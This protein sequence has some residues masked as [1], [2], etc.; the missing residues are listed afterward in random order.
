MSVERTR[1]AVMA[2]P[3]LAPEWPIV[4]RV[5]VLYTPS[6]YLGKGGRRQAPQQR[7]RRR[8]TQQDDGFGAPS[9]HDRS[10]SSVIAPEPYLQKALLFGLPS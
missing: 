1:S 7:A 6:T 2:R 4:F 10:I 9:T 3:A 8:V 5:I